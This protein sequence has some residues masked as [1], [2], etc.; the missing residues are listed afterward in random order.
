MRSVTT[1][2]RKWFSPTEYAD[3]TGMHPE[4]VRTMCRRGELK[5]R[6]Q[7]MRRWQIHY[8]EVE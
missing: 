1:V 5:C 8:S 4:T 3:M 7:G 6:K 2:N